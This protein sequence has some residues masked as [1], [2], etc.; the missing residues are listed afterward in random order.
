MLEEIEDMAIHH[1][2]V[3]GEPANALFIPD[4]FRQPFLDAVF[5]LFN[6][7]KHHQE[8]TKTEPM[9][10]KGMGCFFN[11]ED[12]YFNVGRVERIAQ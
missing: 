12:E 8:S 2:E 1:E 11:S 9:T 6:I 4:H 3:S 5:E 10:Y 7:P